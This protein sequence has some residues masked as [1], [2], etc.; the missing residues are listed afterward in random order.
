MDESSPLKE[1]LAENARLL[2]EK[3]GVQ[4]ELENFRSI[5]ACEKVEA[6]FELNKEL[7]VL[8]SKI[9]M[10]DHDIRNLKLEHNQ[11]IASLRSDLTAANSRRGS[12]QNSEFNRGGSSFARIGV[13]PGLC[14]Q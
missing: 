6:T 10:K 1:L 7:D 12:S 14:A 2:Q 5:V 4:E 13:C 9:N 11:K 3:E 8:R